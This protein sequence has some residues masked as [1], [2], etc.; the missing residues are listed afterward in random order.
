MPSAT[1][2]IFEGKEEEGL[3]YIVT[4]LAPK[5]NLSSG[6]L[7]FFPGAEELRECRSVRLLDIPLQR[8]KLVNG[9]ILLYSPTRTG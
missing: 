5:V 9:N 4:V 8:Q 7:S 3:K 1:R 2:Q 6:K